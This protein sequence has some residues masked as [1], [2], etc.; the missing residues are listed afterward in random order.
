MDRE[1][2]KTE[3]YFLSHSRLWPLSLAIVTSHQS[4][5][6]SYQ[7]LSLEAAYLSWLSCQFPSPAVMW[8]L[9]CHMRCWSWVAHGL[10]QSLSLILWVALPVC[11][12]FLTSDR[13]KNVLESLR[14]KTGGMDFLQLWAM[15][16]N[17]ST[18]INFYSMIVIRLSDS[19]Y[20]VKWYLFSTIWIRKK[21]WLPISHKIFILTYSYLATFYRWLTY[22]YVRLFIYQLMTDLMWW[23]N[24]TFWVVFLRSSIFC[25]A[26]THWYQLR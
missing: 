10:S 12:T 20:C 7:N 15:I 3:K 13:K 19:L 26:L 5:V 9:T 2:E 18:A 8:H 17:I 6:T 1:K 23:A 21:C 14:K 16:W 22:L 4:P 11:L 24:L 25:R